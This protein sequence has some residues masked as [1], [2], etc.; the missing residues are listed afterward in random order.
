[1]IFAALVYVYRSSA[2]ATDYG[3]AEA[4]SNEIE[5]CKE[6]D[7]MAELTAESNEFVG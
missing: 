1:M 2:L 7:V 6:D 3:A 5:E 4:E